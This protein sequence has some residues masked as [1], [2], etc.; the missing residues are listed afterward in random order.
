M[1]KSLVILLSLIVFAPLMALAQA[2]FN[3]QYIISDNEMFDYKGWTIS[4]IQK[5][6]EARGSYLANYQ[7]ED[8][9]G[10]LRTAAGIIYDSS[11]TNQVNPKYLL[12][13]L[14]KEQ[15]LITDDSP[16]QKQL[17]WATGYA[18]CDSCDRL[19]PKVA[20]H[21][22]FAKQVDDAGSIMRWYYNNKDSNPIIKKKDITLNIDDTAVTPQSWATAFLYTYTP[23]L[24]GNQNFWRIWQT[25]FTQNYPDGTLVKSNEASSTDVWLLQNGT[26]RKFKNQAV[27]ISRADPKFIVSVAPSELDNYKTGSDIS[28]PNYS[29]LRTELGQY[30]LIDFD[31]IRPFDSE[32]TVRRL[33]FQPDETIDVS[34]SDLISYALGPSI[35]VSSTAPTGVIYQIADLNNS[36][37]LL[38]DNNF[39]PITDK[40]L[41]T[42]NYKNIQI[43]KHT[44]KDLALYPVVYDTPDIKDGLLL[45]E[46]DS[47][48]VYV[49]EK[50][51]KRQL[52]DSDTFDAMGYKKENVISV[53]IATLIGI[54]E[55]DKI[56]LNGSLLNAKEKFL[57]DSEAEIKDNYGSKLPEYLVAEYPSGRILS[58][59]NID[60]KRSIASLT[61][62]ITALTVLGEKYKP[63]QTITY[64]TNLY[65]VEGG[66]L[67]IKDGEK[68]TA[69]DAFNAMLVGSA[70]NTTRMLAQATGLTEKNFIAEM[71]KNLDTWGMDNSKVSDVTGLD[72]NNKSTSRDL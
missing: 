29:I 36:Y 21:K 13:T 61:K 47:D 24:H 23:H 16:A 15:S 28:L 67:A 42:T 14:Q 63:T 8:L 30:Y 54:P 31:A 26:K 69:K 37:Y 39:Y 72:P 20:K 1:K 52:A 51:K 68:I 53:N 18:V 34:S 40:N 4:D 56:F 7:T 66:N 6:L 71:N 43:E 3:P 41:L 38:K 10:N 19:D 55:G 58:G 5:F 22:G 50:G 46:T 65:G 32:N 9:S 49:I 48:T 12:V 35:T 62:L 60:T 45:K 44:K 17:D 33:G 27:L 11:Q 2:D 57:G 25:W 64:S 70:N 59:K